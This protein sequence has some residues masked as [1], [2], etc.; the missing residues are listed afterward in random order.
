M[1][2]M[3]GE[4]LMFLLYYNHYTHSILTCRYELEVGAFDSGVPDFHTGTTRL[5][6][7]VLDTNDNI[8]RFDRSFYDVAISESK[9][10]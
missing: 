3:H 2:L 1:N 5:I 8:P 10:A 4:F 9:R 7:S 6:I